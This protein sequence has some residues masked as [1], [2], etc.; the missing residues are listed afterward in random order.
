MEDIFITLH[1]H[2]ECVVNPVLHF[3]RNSPFYRSVRFVSPDTG[4]R[5]IFHKVE[6]EVDSFMENRWLQKISRF[7]ILEYIGWINVFSVW[8]DYIGRCG[9]PRGA[10]N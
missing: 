7:D 5:K 3:S 10:L 4:F 2:N 6:M 8:Q 1:T 9:V